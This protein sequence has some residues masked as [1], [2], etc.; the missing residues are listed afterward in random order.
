MMGNNT[1]TKDNR[2]P[3]DIGSETLLA[4]ENV[5]FARQQGTKCFTVGAVKRY[6]ILRQEV[7]VCYFFCQIVMVSSSFS[8][9]IFVLLFFVYVYLRGKL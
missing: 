9:T 7:D 2:E 1:L 6:V 3:Y 8:P 5:A 4:P